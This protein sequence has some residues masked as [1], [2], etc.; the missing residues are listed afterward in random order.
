MENYC[1]KSVLAG[2]QTMNKTTG[3]LIGPAFRKVR[4]LWKWQGRNLKK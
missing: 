3:E 4:D 2:W 1:C